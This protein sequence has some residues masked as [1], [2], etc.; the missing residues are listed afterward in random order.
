MKIGTTELVI[1]LVVVIIIFGPTQIP[2]LTRMLGKS[3]KELRKGMSEDE[4]ADSSAAEK[5]VDTTID[6]NNLNM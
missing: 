4:D 1:I 2:K 5:T 6:Q 3:M